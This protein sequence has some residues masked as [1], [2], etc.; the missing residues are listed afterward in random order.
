MEAEHAK[1][2][3]TAERPPVSFSHSICDFVECLPDRDACPHKSFRLGES[4]WSAGLHESNLLERA[5]QARDGLKYG[6]VRTRYVLEADVRQMPVH[7]V[8]VASGQRCPRI[9]VDGISVM[10]PCIPVV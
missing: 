1:L 10:R 8:R 9:Y 7:K 5:G 2:L 3:G 6:F 4:R